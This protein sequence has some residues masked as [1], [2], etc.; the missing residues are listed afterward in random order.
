M[1]TKFTLSKIY[2]LLLSDFMVLVNK[3]NILDCIS[4]NIQ[5]IPSQNLYN[6]WKLYWFANKICFDT[7]VVLFKD[8]SL[9]PLRYISI[10]CLSM[11]LLL[12]YHVYFNVQIAWL[13]HVFFFIFYYIIQNF[14]HYCWKYICH[15]N[16]RLNQGINKIFCDLA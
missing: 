15:P 3:C 11:K 13:K 12:V 16:I 10:L 8:F 4:I 7:F 14:Y 5:L 9:Q 2:N 1:S 6:K